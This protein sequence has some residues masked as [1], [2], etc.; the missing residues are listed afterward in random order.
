M[1]PYSSNSYVSPL[2]EGVLNLMMFEQRSLTNIY[3]QVLKALARTGNHQFSLKVIGPSGP[4][5]DKMVKDLPIENC[6]YF[7]SNYDVT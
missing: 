1:Q 5:M 4:S 3:V 7:I 2:C 6:F